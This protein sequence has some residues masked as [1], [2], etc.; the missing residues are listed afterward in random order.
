MI[1]KNRANRRRVAIAKATRK[2]NL[3]MDVISRNLWQGTYD[4]LHQYS[5]NKVTEAGPKWIK[6]F[7]N[8]ATKPTGHPK[9]VAVK[10]MSMAYQ[11][12]DEGLTD[13]RN[14]INAYSLVSDVP[15]DYD[16]E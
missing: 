6:P 8:S 4:N 14:N 7:K 13:M 15:A 3:D 10:L 9:R 2:Y 1:H 12:K 5:K 11:L 16:C